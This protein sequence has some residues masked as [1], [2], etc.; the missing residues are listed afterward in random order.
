MKKKI[1]MLAGLALAAMALVGCGH[2]SEDNNNPAPTNSADN[3]PMPGAAASNNVN[4]T[5]VP[6]GVAWNNTNNPAPTNQPG[7]NNPSAT[8]R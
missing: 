2:H 7:S 4:N 6:P 5:A 8:N 1:I 3:Q